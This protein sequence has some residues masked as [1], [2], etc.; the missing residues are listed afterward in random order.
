VVQLDEV[1][2]A[3]EGRQGAVA[4]D[5]GIFMSRGIATSYLVTTSDG[6]VLVNTGLDFEAAE[7][8]AR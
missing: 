3:G 7:I 1:I 6:D 5:D 8:A 4:V 2:K